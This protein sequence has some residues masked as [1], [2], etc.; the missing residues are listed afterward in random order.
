MTTARINCAW[1]LAAVMVVA[2]AG[3]GKTEVPTPPPYVMPDVNDTN[4]AKAA[5]EA[6]PVTDAVRREFG[7][8]CARRG[9][10]SPS[11]KKVW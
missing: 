5:I 10:Y 4:C 7:S 2:L 3:C 6:M 8:K 9:S 1:A 11:E